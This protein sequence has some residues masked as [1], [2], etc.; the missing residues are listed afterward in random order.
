MLE[1][2]NALDQMQYEKLTAEEQASRGILGRLV[3]I[4]AD[5]KNPTRNGRKYTESL[6]DKTFENPIIKEKLANRCL[7]G[8]LGHPVDRQ[9]VDMEKIAICMAEAPK[10]GKDGKLHGVFDILSTPNGRILKTLCDYGC[11]IGVSS[12]GSGDTFTDYD[13]QETVD[14][15]TFE[16]ECWDAVILPAVKEARLKLVT[17]SLDSSRISLKKA[18]QESLADANEAD[19]KVMTETLDELKIDYKESSYETEEEQ[20]VDTEKEVADNN[21]TDLV[22]ELQGALKENQGLQK[23]VLELQ[24][25]LSVSYTKEIKYEESITSLK[26][27]VK[28]LTEDVNKSKALE[29][30][31]STMKLQLQ[32]SVKLNERNKRT[33]KSYREKFKEINDRKS[34]LTESLS[35]KDNHIKKL[36]EKIVSLNEST[37]LN[38]QVA[39]EK[40]QKLN[41]QICELKTDS[42]VKHSQYESKLEKSKKLIESYKQIANKA[43]DKY[44]E[45]KASNLGVNA[46][47][48][49][50]KLNE[51]YSFKDID[52]VCEE[53]RSYKI[54][55]S[56]LP[57]NLDK[58]SVS[59][60]TLKEDTSTSRF[61]NPDDIVDKDL[62]N[63]INN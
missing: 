33:L 54:N 43:V 19:R 41:D 4:I 52:R 48:I 21:G 24:E 38:E 53:L 9:E 11:A 59:K 6:W 51:N 18:L 14:E 57:F 15:D 47:D 49:K 22:S 44:V 3:G 30:Q 46:N 32:E 62:I 28:K 8:E 45:S 17:E 7:F 23:Q 63:L 25:K 20:T 31:L 61:T 35:A 34:T 40:I 27:S 26:Q 1:N 60:V 5:F 12:R 37:Q 55:M 39:Q 56:K 13:G 42:A 2:L 58:H 16:C 29:H 36:K 50:N 10:K